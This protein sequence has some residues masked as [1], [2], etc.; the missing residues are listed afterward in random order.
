[1]EKGKKLLPKNRRAR[2]SEARTAAASARGILDGSL[3]GES[4]SAEIIRAS[5]GEEAGVRTFAVA[6]GTEG[7]HGLQELGMQHS[8]IH[9]IMMSQGTIQWR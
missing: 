6:G 2:G 4:L 1:M 8:D 5:D 7:S 3:C 9:C